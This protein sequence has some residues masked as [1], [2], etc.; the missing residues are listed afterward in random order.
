MSETGGHKVLVY[1]G[2]SPPKIP[3]DHFSPRPAPGPN[4]NFN[5]RN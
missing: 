1:G 2:V 5:W 4:Q 3:Y